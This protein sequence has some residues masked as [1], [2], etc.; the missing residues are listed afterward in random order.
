M[1]DAY[2]RCELFLN[3]LDKGIMD[4]SIIFSR[5]VAVALGLIALVVL[6]GWQLSNAA[7]KSILSMDRVPMVPNSAICFLS[8]GIILFLFTLQTSKTYER[9]ILFL[10]ALIF[11]IGLVTVIEYLAGLSLGIDQFIF[12]H[13][14]L[15]VIFLAE[16]PYSQLLTL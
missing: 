1:I 14:L 16:C 11:L 8:A 4:R 9:V 3:Y 5:S 6:L 12:E 2:A 13:R 7:L 10:S 15:R